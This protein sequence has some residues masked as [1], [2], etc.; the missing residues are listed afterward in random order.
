MTPV[1]SDGSIRTNQHS[2]TASYGGVWDDTG[3]GARRSVCLRTPSAQGT[4]SLCPLG[5]YAQPGGYYEINGGKRAS[6]I[7]GQTPKHETGPSR[8]WPDPTDYTRI[9][10][11]NGSGGK[12]DG[13]IWRPVAPSGYVALGDVGCY[14][15]GKPN[16]NNIW[17]VREDLVGYGKFLAGSAWDDGGSG[18]ATQDVSLWATQTNTVGVDGAANISPSWPTRPPPSPNT[19]RGRFTQ[20]FDVN[21]YYAKVPLLQARVDQVLAPRQP[22][23]PA[24]DGGDGE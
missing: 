20:P 9:W 16:A 24:P 2:M 18:G 15:H 6:L 11:D 10:I 23:R 7:V 14:G 5:D 12:H 19:A 3:S 17:C 4:S 13:A 21:A 1:I 22:R 8:R